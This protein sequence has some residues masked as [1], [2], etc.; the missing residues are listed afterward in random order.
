MSHSSGT[1]VH[2]L[3]LMRH[4][5][6]EGH[7][8]GEAGEGAPGA[9][10]GIAVAL[11]RPQRL[12]ISSLY[13]FKNT[14]QQTPAPRFLN[15]GCIRPLQPSSGRGAAGGLISTGGAHPDWALAGPGA[16]Q[17]H[18]GGDKNERRG[19]LW[20][21]SQGT[22]TSGSHW[23]WQQR[24][25]LEQ[26]PYT[27]LSGWKGRPETRSPRA[28]SALLWGTGLAES[29]LSFLQQVAGLDRSSQVFQCFLGVGLRYSPVWAQSQAHLVTS[30][31]EAAD[32]LNSPAQ[33]Q[34]G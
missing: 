27:K 21:S 7:C 9:H 12:Q 31:S 23:T 29:S 14:H 24:P 32:D 33:R 34:P 5:D 18:Q 3:L 8:R 1:S 11:T 10:G 25:E 16:A 13:M 2:F 20:V 28:L 17:A 26:A 6:F 22:G 19:G 30:T 4:R 15:R